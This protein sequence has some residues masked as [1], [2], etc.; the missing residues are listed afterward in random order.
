MKIFLILIIDYLN[1]Q[2]NLIKSLPDIF[3]SD[4]S[5]LFKKII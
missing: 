4:E 5:E 2:I 3:E 1:E